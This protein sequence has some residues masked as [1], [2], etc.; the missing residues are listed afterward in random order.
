LAQ[1]RLPLIK[2]ND[3]FEHVRESSLISPDQILDAIKDQNTLSSSQLKYRGFLCKTHFL[4]K[5]KIIV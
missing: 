4:L 2:V 1:I 5:L 3:L